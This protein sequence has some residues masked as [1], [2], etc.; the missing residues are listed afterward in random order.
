MLIVYT[1]PEEFSHG[2]I[3]YFQDASGAGTEIPLEVEMLIKYSCKGM[4]LNCPF[5]L[6]GETVEEV[7]KKAFEHV[8]EQ[9]VNDFNSFESPTEIEQ[10][11]Q[12]LARSTHVVAG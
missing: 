11:E 12:A 4:G 6:T 8:R 10:M 1:I 5:F 9:H 3:G 7:T 2:L